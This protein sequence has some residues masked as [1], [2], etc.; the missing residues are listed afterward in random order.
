MKPRIFFIVGALVLLLIPL[1]V[2]A[3]EENT[4][5]DVESQ[6]RNLQY[7][8]DPV[9]FH[10]GEGFDIQKT[11]GSG[12]IGAK[13]CKHFQGLARMDYKGTPY[14]FLTRSG[15][16]TCTKIGGVGIAGCCGDPDNPGELL[17]VKMGSRDAAGGRL[18]PTD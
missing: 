3:E 4:V 9:A 17:I 2:S 5:P 18:A 13:Y 12:L 11:I 8:G 15:N 10:L 1:S 7:H 14:F 16:H 6:F